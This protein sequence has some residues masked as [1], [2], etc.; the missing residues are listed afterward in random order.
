MQS[1]TTSPK[2]MAILIWLSILILEGVTAMMIEGTGEGPLRG[3][4]AMAADA[5]VLQQGMATAPM[6]MEALVDA[7]AAGTS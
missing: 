6:P 7:M 4:H 5:I 2:G 1:G 3:T